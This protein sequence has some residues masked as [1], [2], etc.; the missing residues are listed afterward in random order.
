MYVVSVR[1]GIL[2]KKVNSMYHRTSGQQNIFLKD[3]I[4]LYNHFRCGKFQV[5]QKTWLRAH[6]GEMIHSGPSE[7]SK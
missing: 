2:T 4:V 6:I 7:I 1:D 3:G 5:C